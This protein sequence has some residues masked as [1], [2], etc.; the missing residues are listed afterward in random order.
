MQ[1]RAPRIKPPASRRVLGV[2]ESQRQS[3][4]SGQQQN[5]SRLV[6]DVVVSTIV[7]AYHDRRHAAGVEAGGEAADEAAALRDLVTGIERAMR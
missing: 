7:D 3:K 4:W 1:P 2:E 5:P 6:S